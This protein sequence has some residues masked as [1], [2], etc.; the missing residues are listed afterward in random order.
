MAQSHAGMNRSAA[1]IAKSILGPSLGGA[2]KS[3]WFHLVYNDVLT[4]DRLSDE[5]LKPLFPSF[6]HWTDKKNECVVGSF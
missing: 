5:R 3:V 6:S 4:L 1:R 2:G